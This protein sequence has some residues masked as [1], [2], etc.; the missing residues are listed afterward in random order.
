MPIRCNVYS[1]PRTVP[2]KTLPFFLEEESDE[3]EE[4][5]EVCV[6]S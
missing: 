2:P 1:A 6:A 5:E 3:E 4:V